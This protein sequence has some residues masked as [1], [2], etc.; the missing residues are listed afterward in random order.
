LRALNDSG[1]QITAMF[2]PASRALRPF[3]DERSATEAAISALPA[4]ETDGIDAGLGGSGKRL[5]DSLGSVLTAAAPVLPDLPRAFQNATT[6]LKVGDGQTRTG[7]GIAP[8][9]GLKQVLD[10]VPSAVPAGLAILRSLKPDLAPLRR[11]FTDLVGPVTSLSL[12]GCDIQSFATNI[13]SLVGIGTEPGGHF[14]PDG[15]FPVSVAVSPAEANNDF[16]TP[17]RYP[18]VHQY[19]PPCAY[20]PG[21]VIPGSTLLQVMAGVFR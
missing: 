13:A 20:S 8:L 6:L 19:Y 21:P 7:T 9:T 5:L 18:V 10:R 16:D 11:E 2:G 12:H 4:A 17:F 1:D 14:G 3:V 15:G